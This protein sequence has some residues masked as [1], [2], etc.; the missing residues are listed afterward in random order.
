MPIIIMCVY[1][2]IGILNF[3]L[4][5][6]WKLAIYYITYSKSYPHKKINN[7]MLIYIIN[8]IYLKKFHQIFVL[9]ISCM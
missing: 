7:R 3:P 9:T 2:N 4:F 6:T 5:W 8:Y 1:I